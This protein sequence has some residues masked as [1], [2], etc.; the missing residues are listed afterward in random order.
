MMT[1]EER[2]IKIRSIIREAEEA[3]NR[4]DCNQLVVLR[5]AFLDIILAAGPQPSGRRRPSHEQ[6][7]C[8]ERTV[9]VTETIVKP[10]QRC[11]P[12]RIIRPVEKDNQESVPQPSEDDNA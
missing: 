4:V 9:Q 7:V 6:V 11:P 8:I 5:S 10:I 12:R 2:L 3:F 1:A